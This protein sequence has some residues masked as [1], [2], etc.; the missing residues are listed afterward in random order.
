[1]P[2]CQD[3]PFSDQTEL[4]KLF[5]KISFGS[6]WLKG[7]KLNWENSIYHTIYHRFLKFGLFPSYL[8]T[9]SWKP[10]LQIQGPS[11][12]TLKTKDMRVYTIPLSSLPKIICLLLL[13]NKSEITI[14]QPWPLTIEYRP[15]EVGLLFHYF[16]Q[17]KF[18]KRRQRKFSNWISAVSA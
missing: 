17:S 8:I 4:W 6:L 18:P 5:S 7:A 12:R 10:K 14:H 3:Q 11:D 1:M 2:L 16:S 9:K 15:S 13:F